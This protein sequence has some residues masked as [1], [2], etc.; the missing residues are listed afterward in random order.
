MDREAYQRW[1][2]E[3]WAE[4]ER[5]F[6][7]VFGRTEPPNSVIAF[8]WDEF[9]LEIPGACAMVFP[10]QPGQ[11]E[12]WLTLTHGLTQ[13]ESPQDVLAQD[14]PSGYGAEF[15]FITREKADWAP[16]ALRL[17]LTYLKQSG[18]RIERG[19]RVPFWF[20]RDSSQ[21]LVGEIG[22]VGPQET[23]SPVGEMRALVFRPH[24]RYPSGFETSTGFFNIL[25]GTAITEKEWQFAKETSSA[26]LL[27]ILLMAG[28][29]QHS[30]L[31]RSCVMTGDTLQTEWER[32]SSLTEAAAEQELLRFC[33]MT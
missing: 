10:P 25:V 18:R 28:N 6:H 27:L 33:K 21:N 14:E 12:Y 19:N 1:W 11:R 3:K 13:P 26:H 22:K 20:S 8:Y 17:L 24:M 32:L 31:T 4:R 23:R 30:D 15:G 5:L 7:S 9:D 16:D 29:G 2:E